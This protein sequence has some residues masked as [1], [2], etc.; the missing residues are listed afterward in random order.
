LYGAHFSITRVHGIKGFLRM[1]KHLVAALSFLCLSAACSSGTAP[2]SDDQSEVSVFTLAFAS[3]ANQYE[4]QAVWTEIA[5]TQPD[6]FLFIGDNV[7]AD[8]YMVD[9]KRKKN[10]AQSKERFEKAYALA[11][12]IPEFAAFRKQDSWHRDQRLGHREDDGQEKPWLS[13]FGT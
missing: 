13:V 9:G 3:C 12:A 6:V 2:S 8:I 11:N 10:P 7:Y 5:K 1:K 4:P